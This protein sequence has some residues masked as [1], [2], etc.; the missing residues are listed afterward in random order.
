[1]K[2]TF[3][4]H[5]ET[6]AERLLQATL[7][8]SANEGKKEESKPL[9]EVEEQ[10]HWNDLEK[11]LDQVLHQVLT[12]HEREIV[13]LRYGI[14]DGYVY[15]LEEVAKIFVVTQERVRQVEAKAIGKLKDSTSVSDLVEIFLS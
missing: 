3:M 4:M 9:T 8:R 2:G 1:M 11:R 6:P 10:A 12:Y 15:T 5:V 13:K 7:K 14:G